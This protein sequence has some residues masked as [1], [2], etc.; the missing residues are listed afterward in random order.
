MYVCVRRGDKRVRVYVFTR[1]CVYVGVKR[2]AC[3]WSLRVHKYGRV[4]V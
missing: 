2:F 1:M 3:V 4:C